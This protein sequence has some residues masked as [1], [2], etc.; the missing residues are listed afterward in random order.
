MIIQEPLCRERNDFG[1]NSEL[2]EQMRS[3]CRQVGKELRGLGD[4]L[5][6]Q[7]L[8]PLQGAGRNR[9]IIAIDIGRNMIDI[10]RFVLLRCLRELLGLNN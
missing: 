4:A 6:D 2:N 10:T 3:L 1:A 5:E 7:Y 9:R 8:R